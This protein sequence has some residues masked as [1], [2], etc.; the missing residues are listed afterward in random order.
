MKV[1]M[2]AAMAHPRYG[3]A[4][5]GQVIEL[6]EAAAR[7]MIAGGFA[8]PVVDQRKPETTAIAG[9]PDRA[10]QMR[11]DPR[12]RKTPAPPAKHEDKAEAAAK[13]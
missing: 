12:D 7:S 8:E 5:P 9:P 1:K 13:K 2:R 10:M 11:P 6:P 4:K 3:V